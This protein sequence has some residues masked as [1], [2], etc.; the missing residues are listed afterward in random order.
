[1]FDETITLMRMELGHRAAVEFGEKLL[2]SSATQLFSVSLDDRKA[3]WETFKKYKDQRFSFTDCTSFIVM[4]RMGIRKA[5]ATD[6][7]FK[8]SGFTLVLES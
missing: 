5:L 4:R 8:V 2:K 6:R 1:M 3:A 7:H